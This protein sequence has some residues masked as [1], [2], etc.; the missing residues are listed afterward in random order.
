MDHAGKATLFDR[1]QPALTEEPGADRYAAIAREL[2]TSESAIKTA[3][4]RLRRRYREV[5]R[6]EIARTIAD[7]ATIDEEVRALFVALGR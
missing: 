7:P 1:L 5:L 3:A 6:E 4:M 2:G